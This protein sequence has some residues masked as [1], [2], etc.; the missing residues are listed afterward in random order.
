MSSNMYIEI[1]TPEK[2]LWQGDIKEVTGPGFLGEFGVLPEHA[3][4]ITS[5]EI[6]PMHFVTADG[7]NK[8]VCS[9]RRILRD[10][11]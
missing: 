5:L 11:G 1:V 8:W 9:S 3:P 4:Y 6:G 2:M 10:S 7:E